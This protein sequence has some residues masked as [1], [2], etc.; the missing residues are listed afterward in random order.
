MAQPSRMP[1]PRVS[2]VGIHIQVI[3]PIT[4]LPIM[5]PPKVA[6]VIAPPPKSRKNTITT[7][8][9]MIRGVLFVAFMRM[10]LLNSLLDICR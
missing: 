9:A 1:R 3:P 5:P 10:P 6:P 8:K 2:K 4:P 7:T